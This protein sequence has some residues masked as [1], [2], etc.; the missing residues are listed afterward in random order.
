MQETAPRLTEQEFDRRLQEKLDTMIQQDEVFFFRS[1]M[2]HSPEARRYMAD[3]LRD[4]IEQDWAD[5][6]EDGFID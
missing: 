5:D 6:V 1:M 3:A 4:E 2:M